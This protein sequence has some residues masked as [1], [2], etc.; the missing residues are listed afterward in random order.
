MPAGA[1]EGPVS[2]RRV[3]AAAAQLGA[4]RRGRGGGDIGL[5]GHPR[6]CDGEARQHC[7]ADDDRQKKLPGR[8]PETCPNFAHDRC[9]DSSPRDTLHAAAPPALPYGNSLSASGPSRYVSM[10]QEVAAPGTYASER[11]L[12]ISLERG[13]ATPLR[14]GRPGLGL[15]RALGRA[16]KTPRSLGSRTAAIRQPDRDRTVSG[17]RISALASRRWS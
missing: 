11:R 15:P 3:S 1:D 6:E 13:V 17:S 12:G 8:P 7:A 10:R 9:S 14:P 4:R 2:R 5:G 16:K